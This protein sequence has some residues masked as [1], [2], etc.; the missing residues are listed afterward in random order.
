MIV[1]PNSPS[2]RAQLITRP[3]ASGRAGERHRDRPEQLALGGAVDP[4]GVLQVAVDAGEPGPGRADEERRRDERLGQD[5]GQRRERQLDPERVERLAEEAAPP[6][7]SSSA[8]PAT[9]GGSTI[10]RSTIA[11]SRPRAAEP[12]AG[13]DEGQRQAERDREHQADRGRGQAEG[14]R[15]E[16]DRRAERRASEPSRTARA[17]ERRATGRP[18]NSATA[19]AQ[20]TA[21]A[22]PKRRPPTPAPGAT[23]PSTRLAAIAAG[24]VG[25]PSSRRAAG[26]RS[27]PRIAWPSG[28]ASQVR[29][30]AAAA[31]FA[32]ALTT[33]PAVG[34]GDV[35]GGRDGD[36][37]DLRRRLRVGHVDDRR[38]RPRR[39]RSWR[40]PPRRC[41]PS[42]R[43]WRCTRRRS[44]AG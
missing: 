1:A 32:D 40:R 18:R 26:T 25:S 24:L 19:P 30:A 27:A 6:E 16:D 41:P 2:A 11:S 20:A 39:A 38:R 43:C 31:A 10:G 33:T 12:A 37:R 13:E 44:P 36:R 42:T 3:A 15:V 9:D 35:R 14:E 34:R 28:P 4:R 22:R 23:R 8:S 7:A 17:D 21:S 5:H 29:N